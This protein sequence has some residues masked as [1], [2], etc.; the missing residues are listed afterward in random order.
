MTPEQ[1]AAA[2]DG[3]VGRKIEEQIEQ[4]KLQPGS[5]PPDAGNMT[6]LVLALLE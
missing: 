6:G 3:T 4:H 1:V 2:I 5:L